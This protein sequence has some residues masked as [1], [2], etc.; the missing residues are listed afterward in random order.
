MAPDVGFIL[1]EGFLEDL[2]EIAGEG[3]HDGDVIIHV[4]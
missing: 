4:L 2:F 1:E 3:A